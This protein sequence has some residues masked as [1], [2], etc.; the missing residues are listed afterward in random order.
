MRYATFINWTEKPF[1]GYWDGKPYT[2]Q[3]GQKKERLN[4][5]IASHF[6]KHLTNQALQDPD[7]KIKDGERYTS[8]K[9]PDEVPIFMD[10][11]NKAFKLEGHGEEINAETGLPIDQINP[12]LGINDANVPSMNIN[13]ISGKIVDPYDAHSQPVVGP[14]DKSQIIGDDLTEENLVEEDAFEGNKKENLA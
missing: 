1:I 9:K 3:P 10:L 6:A 12:R 7:N 4:E 13:V 2:F 14:G 11:F 5:S 8:P